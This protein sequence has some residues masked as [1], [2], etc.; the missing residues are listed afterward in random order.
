MIALP[1]SVYPLGCC[2]G[3]KTKNGIGWVS[4]MSASVGYTSGVFHLY[5]SNPTMQYDWADQSVSFSFI[6]KY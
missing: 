1:V 4:G 5:L 2:V 6:A 3:S